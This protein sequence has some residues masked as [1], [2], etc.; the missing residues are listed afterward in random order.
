MKRLVGFLG[1]ALVA[2]TSAR[3]HAADVG[4]VDGA[5]VR[6]DVTET[7]LLNWHGDNRNGLRRIDDNYGEWINRLNVLVA[8]RAWQL[9][10]RL[11]TVV[12]A[13]A[14]TRSEF[15]GNPD[16]S[17]A[18]QNDAIRQ[19]PYRYRNTFL[20]QGNFHPH[21]RDPS[22]WPS[23][24]FLSYVKPDVEVTLGDAYVAFGRGLVLNI[25]K[26]DEIGA[27]TTLQGGKIIYRLKPFTL[28]GVAGLS[29]PTRVDDATGFKLQDANDVCTDGQLPPE[30]P[31]YPANCGKTVY[32][33]RQTWS[34]DM[35]VGARAEARAGA[36]TFGIHV[37]DVH[38]RQDLQISGDP[39]FVKDVSAYGANVSI[40][41]LSDRVPLNIYGEVA[42]QNRA[43]FDSNEKTTHGY[44]AYGALSLTTG[45]VTTSFEGKHYRDYYPVKLNADPSLYGAFTGVQYTANPTVELITQD[46]LTYNSCTTGGRVRSDVHLAEGYT[47]FV[48]GA[49][50]ENWQLE[51]GA[52]PTLGLTETHDTVDRHDIFDA[53]TGFDL[54]SQTESTWLT[55]MIGTRKEARAIGPDYYREGWIQL[56]G[57]K[58]LGGLWSVEVDA[59]HRNRYQNLEQWREGQTYLGLKFASKRS[60]VIGHEYTTRKSQIPTNGDI[61]S[62]NGSFLNGLRGLTTPGGIQH[63]INIGGQLKFTDDIMLRF[64]VGQQRG[65][66]KCVNGVCRFF[67]PF[68]GVRTEFIVRY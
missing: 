2:T 20:V 9:G 59:W 36:S 25:R 66:L 53:Y 26:F 16:Y 21:P 4:R 18:E 68:E 7:A 60:I 35:I 33:Y 62:W 54:R 42:V 38:R 47:V 1:V 39:T 10:I 61:A 24:I 14:P 44:A 6:V 51:C 50:F 55:V 23:K 49:F 5:P 15:E 19:L 63:Y 37:S 3:A 34:R 12:Y 27:D 11:D 29:N 52:G 40:P 45:P 13:N 58:A 48:S 43:P 41:K 17:T 67:P 32:P 30:T 22:V 8:W 57:S 64:M 31:P 28:T 65:A 46:S 56:N